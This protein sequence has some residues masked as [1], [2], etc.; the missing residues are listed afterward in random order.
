MI[1]HGQ[2]LDRARHVLRRLALA[3]TLMGVPA[4]ALAQTATITG[5]LGGFDVVNDSGQEAHGFEIQLEGVQQADLMYT[6]FGGRYGQA[7]ITPYD[8]GVYVRWVSR[9]DPET[10]HWSATTPQY[11]GGPFSW[12]DCYLAGSRYGVSGCEH[13]GQ[14]LRN[15]SNITKV[16]GYWLVEDS[17]NPGTLVRLL[18]PAA[19][20]FAAWTIA[21]PVV[22]T[23]PVVVAQIE[24]P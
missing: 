9:Y 21:P 4:A 14:S 12:N 7:I 13:F 11:Q 5:N 6:G 22:S 1:T 24:A 17:A 3:A 23:P 18:P 2:G 15:Y 16:S 20:P 19:I 8:T 10:S